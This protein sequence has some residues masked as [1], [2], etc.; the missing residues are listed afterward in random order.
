MTAITASGRLSKPKTA[1]R[2]GTR[3]FVQARHDFRSVIENVAQGG[4]VTGDKRLGVR[5]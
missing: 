2:A 1:N 3:G 4:D 5:T